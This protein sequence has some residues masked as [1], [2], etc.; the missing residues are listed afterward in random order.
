[1]GKSR[2][3]PKKDVALA[4]LESSTVFV[5]LDPRAEGVTVPPWFKKQ[6]QL[7]LQIGLNMP[8]PILDLSLDGDGVSCHRPACFLFIRPRR[9]RRTASDASHLA[10]RSFQVERQSCPESPCKVVVR[11]RTSL[12]G[13]AAHARGSHRAPEA[14]GEATQ[15]I[16]RD[17]AAA[18]RRADADRPCVGPEDSRQEQAAQSPSPHLGKR[19][20]QGIASS[21]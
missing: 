20:A 13:H 10:A 6:P 1:M 12:Y 15:G 16:W 4:L 5:H 3:P 11:L 14:I 17:S 8:V 9:P 19:L 7:V 21:R 2:L 18:P